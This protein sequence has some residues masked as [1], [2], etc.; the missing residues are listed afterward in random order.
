MIARDQVCLGILAGGQGRRLGG[1]D[2]AFLSYDGQTLLERCLQSAGNGFAQRLISHPGSD[3]RFSSNAIEAVH[4]FRPGQQGPLAGLE[5]L[6]SATRSDWLLTVPVDAKTLPLVVFETLLRQEQGAGRVIRDADGLQ[7][8]VA[9]WRVSA[10]LPVV[11]QRLDSA[12][13]D[14]HGLVAALGLTV[15]ELAPVRLGNLNTP[16]DF[17]E[18]RP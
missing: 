6:L 5:A 12:Q 17:Q 15:C 8:L 4:D 16:N 13:R 18:S 2:K 3:V 9:L 7:P 11:R 1:V 10:A 14:A